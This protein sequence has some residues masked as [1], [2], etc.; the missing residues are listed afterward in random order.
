MTI[1][2]PAIMD[3]DTF[4]RVNRITPRTGG[5][6]H[7]PPAPTRICC[8]DS[9]SAITVALLRL[10]QRRREEGHTRAV[11]LVQDRDVVRARSEDRLA[12]TLDPRRRA[13]RYVFEQ[14]RQALLDP[15]QLLAGE[16]AVLAGAP[17]ENEL[18]T[19]QLKR[20]SAAIDADAATRAATRRLSGRP[21]RARQLTR[22]TSALT[23][24]HDRLVQERDTLP[25]RSAELATQSRLSSPSRRVRRTDRRIAGR[26][27]LRRPPTP[28]QASSSEYTSAAGASKSTLRSP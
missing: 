6:V 2:V 13:R 19:G 11:L 20:L 16:R 24:R 15:R 23:A 10:A 1:P 7:A 9:A 5:G 3:S 18:I 12:G 21:V 28:V 14:R 25:A 8:P 22:R 27:R 4:G 26:A 17:D